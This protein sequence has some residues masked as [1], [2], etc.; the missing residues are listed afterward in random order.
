MSSSKMADRVKVNTDSFSVTE[1]LGSFIQ[2]ND[3]ASGFNRFQNLS[4]DCTQDHNVFIYTMLSAIADEIGQTVYDNVK[5]YI[6]RVSN[7]DTCKIKSLKSMLKLFGFS[8]TLF[9]QIE[10]F[11]QEILNLADIL[12]IDKKYLLKT[13]LLDPEFFNELVE[14]AANPRAVDDPLFHRCVDFRRLT[15]TNSY[16]LRGVG[17]SFSS[18][19]TIDA[20][21]IF[22]VY[23]Q[24]SATSASADTFTNDYGFQ[25]KS[26]ELSVS[27]LYSPAGKMILAF[28]APKVSSEFCSLSTCCQSAMFEVKDLSSDKIEDDSFI[29]LNE[30]LSVCTMLTNFRKEDIF[31]YDDRAFQDFVEDIFFNVISGFVALRY[32]YTPLGTS[33]KAIEQANLVYPHI[34][35]QYFNATSQDQFT[36]IGEDTVLSIKAFYHIPKSFDEAATVDAIEAG[37]ADL[38][39]YTGPELS[40]IQHEMSLRKQGL[41]SSTSTI[42]NVTLQ[43]RYSYYREQKVLEYA[44]FV[45]NYFSSANQ[46][47]DQY[48]VDPNYHIV[49]NTSLSTVIKKNPVGIISSDIDFGMIQ[50]VAHYLAKIVSYIA[51]IRIKLKQQ[52]QKNYM[53][54]TNLLFIYIVNEW[55]IDY[56]KA[57]SAALS[58]NGLETICKNLSAHQFK[59][60]DGESYTINPVEYYDPTQ[61][62]NI[63]GVTTLSAELSDE[64]N[65]RYWEQTTIGQT[66]MKFDAPAFTLNEIEN[67]YLSVLNTRDA[68]SGDLQA[69]LS[70]LF[71]LGADSSFIFNLGGDQSMSAFASM[72]ST[73]EYS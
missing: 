29:A 39:D 30:D 33:A 14:K 5:N 66:A 46:A 71:S 68:V 69:F 12:S 24:Q 2:N 31:T 34:L 43:T 52:T 42:G 28:S 8:Y 64:A 40:I 20:K 10:K 9:D 65:P 27:N 67:L 23:Q 50:N 26:D 54:G 37:N 32:N 56:A 25:L 22:G 1:T 51:S 57:N 45:D 15:T 17:S 6:D 61:Y 58:A 21:K 53:K 47:F 18:S 73:G 72:L 7:V 49:S 35:D 63:S 44:K 60:D 3:F 59:L 48:L 16:V 11:P 36:P 55:L 41:K 38:D 70:T 19:M 62:M 13:S 4:S